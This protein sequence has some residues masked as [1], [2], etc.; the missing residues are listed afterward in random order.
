MIE[1][2]FGKVEVPVWLVTSADE[3]RRGGLVATFVNEASIVP[4][5]PRVV[6]G[7]ANHHFTWSLIEA[8]DTF[9]L[10]LVGDDQM[11]LIADFG[12]RSGH[13]ADK[14]SQR[15]Y[16]EGKTGSPILSDAPAWLEC[17][18]EERME[19]GD[20]TLYLAEV[21]AGKVVRPFTPMTNTTMFSLATPEQ[22]RHLREQMEKDRATDATRIA[23][24]RAQREEA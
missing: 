17:R 1:Q 6:I 4:E 10:H 5:M 23:Q 19:T 13:H 7:L 18:V 14:L 22:K 15:A 12:M 9:A 8:S 16:T 3:D 2:V 21:V 24:W 20:R 11:D